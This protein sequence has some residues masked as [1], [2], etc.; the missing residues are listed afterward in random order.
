M[1]LALLGDIALF[2]RLSY[3][4]ANDVNSYFE[5]VAKVLDNMDYIVGNLETPF[6]IKKKTFGSKSAYICSDVENVQVLKL[7][8]INAVC[9]ANNH[10]FDF[11]EEGYITTKKVLTENQIDYFG[12]EGKEIQIELGGNKIALSGF[13]CY[14]SN[15]LQCVGYG[16]YGVN[17]YNLGK[18][19]KVLK[20]N[21]N[22]GYLNIMA[23]HAGV[24]HVN[25]PSLDH[26]YAARKLA[27]VSPMVYYGHH[28]HVVQGIEKRND[29]LIAYSLGNFC[30]DDVYSSV[31]KEPLIT[32]SENNR[33][34]CILVI[35]IED[36]KI[37]SYEI[38]PIYIG[39]DKLHVGKGSTKD[40]IAKYSMAIHQMLP[41]EYEEMRN[42]YLNE[43][44]DARKSKRDILWYLKRL[45]PRYL[46]IMLNARKNKKKYKE[47]VRDYINKNEIVES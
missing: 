10:M 31:S 28:P 22:K 4:N 45:R 37:E 29:S 5:D 23:V 39:K 25:Y 43:Y 7:L 24:E 17:A 20:R 36:S 42:T 9:L 18:A 14:T 27:D 3:K 13:C 16:G 34:S 35:S 6:S 40:E 19:M 46:G 44:Y 2:G 21:S 47:C 41:N 1:K 26:I 11:G 12:T 15:P 33:S 32:L 8:H 38:I 30:F